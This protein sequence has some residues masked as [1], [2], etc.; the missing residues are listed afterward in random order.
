M[1]LQILF[2]R[3]IRGP[4]SYVRTEPFRRH[5]D[6]SEEIPARA[7][8]FNGCD[9]GMMPKHSL[10]IACA[11][12]ALYMPGNGLSP[13]MHLGLRK[14]AESLIDPDWNEKPVCVL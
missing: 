4:M 9:A 1:N 12:E 10:R 8:E 11:T 2:G 13:T 5:F 7:Q 14:I 6:I 3:L